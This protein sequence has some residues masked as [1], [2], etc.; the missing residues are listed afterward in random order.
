MKSKFDK[1]SEHIRQFSLIVDCFERS[2]SPPLYYDSGIQHAGFRYGKPTAKHFCILKAVRAIS[3]LNAAVAL[4]EKGFNQ[5]VCVL[6]RTIIECNT[7]IEFVLSGLKEDNLAEK[8]KEIVDSFFEDFHRNTPDDFKGASIR[9]EDVHKEINRHMEKEGITGSDGRFKDINIKTLMSG[10]YRNYSNY[11]HARYPEIMDMYGGAPPRFHMN[12]MSGTPKDAESLILI[13]T[14]TDSVAITLG[15]MIQK[16]DMVEVIG[17]IPQLAH[18][19]K[20][21]KSKNKNTI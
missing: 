13:E 8:Q 5:E 19:V 9:Q 16:L 14:F 17:N 11:I 7:Q 20:I 12:G 18:W 10:V 21:K 15:M 1:I 4:A 6:I 3:G 2:V